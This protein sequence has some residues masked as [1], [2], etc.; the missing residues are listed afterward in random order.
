M[1]A[2]DADATVAQI[3]VDAEG[4]EGVVDL[5]EV[6][7]VFT[8]R[9]AEFDDVVDLAGIDDAQGVDVPVDGVAEFLD[10]PVVIVAQ[11][12]DSPY[13]RWG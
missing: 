7:T 2:G 13:Q 10:P 5:V 4:D 1:H 12:D 3:L 6:Q 9:F 8:K 11:S